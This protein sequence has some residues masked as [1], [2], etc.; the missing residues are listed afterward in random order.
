MKKPQKS[1]PFSLFVHRYEY[2][3]KG[4]CDYL[5]TLS[6]SAQEEKG[7][8]EESRILQNMQQ[9]EGKKLKVFGSSTNNTEA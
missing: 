8:Y 9:S 2:A 5:N 6:L 7:F 1:H 3:N 4:I